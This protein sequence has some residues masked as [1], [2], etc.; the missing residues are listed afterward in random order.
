VT[1]PHFI[2]AVCATKP[3]FIKP[4]CATKPHFISYQT[5]LY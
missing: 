3:H 4:V 1:K 2:N 5:S